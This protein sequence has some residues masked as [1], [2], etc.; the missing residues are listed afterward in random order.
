MAKLEFKFIKER[1]TRIGLSHWVSKKSYGRLHLKQYLMKKK[2][3]EDYQQSILKNFT[4][5][6]ETDRARSF[7]KTAAA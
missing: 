5:A 6:E 7:F 1:N 2:V 4:P 3:R